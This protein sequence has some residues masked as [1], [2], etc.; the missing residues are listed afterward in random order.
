M[1]SASPHVSKTLG[2]SSLSSSR[3]GLVPVASLMSSRHSATTERVRSPSMSILMR[4]RSS[5]SSL[6]NW[7]TRLPSIAAGSTG[8]MSTSGSPVTSIP[9]L[10]IER[11]RGKSITSRHSSRKCCQLCGLMSG[12]GT[13]PN[14]ES[15]TSSLNQRSTP[16]AS[17]SSSSAEKPSALPICRIAMRGWN[18]TTLQTIPVRS[19]PYL[20]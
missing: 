5:T 18:V 3:S 4:P 11:W 14:I 20:S 9:P 8:A 2:S 19:G 13:E 17:R 6:L 12:G 7:T 16:L 1:V 15:S 10:W